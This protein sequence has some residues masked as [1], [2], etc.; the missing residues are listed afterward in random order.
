M[1]KSFNKKLIKKL[2]DRRMDKYW[3][4]YNDRCCPKNTRYF[5]LDGTKWKPSIDMVIRK[6]HKGLANE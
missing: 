3:K 1:N 5:N 4:A 2:K 6:W